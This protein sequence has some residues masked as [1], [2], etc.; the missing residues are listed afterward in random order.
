MTNSS[1]TTRPNQ[2]MQSCPRTYCQGYWSGYRSGWNENL[3]GD[4]NGPCF[5]G[6]QQSILGKCIS[7]VRI[8]SNDYEQGYG[9]ASS[10]MSVKGINHV[11]NAGWLLQIS[12]RICDVL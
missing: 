1:V 9:Q 7:G 8:D 6:M 10:D 2:T 5:P 11:A 3:D 12:I 4:A